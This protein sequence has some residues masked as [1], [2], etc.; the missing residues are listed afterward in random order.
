M[1]DTEE[2]LASLTDKELINAFEVAK[3]D[4]REAADTEQNSEWHGSC[5]A[6]VLVFATEVQKRGLSICTVH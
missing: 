5:F 2:Y 1:I 6:G 4:L 3:V